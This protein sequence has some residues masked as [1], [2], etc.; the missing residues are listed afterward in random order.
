[1]N[2]RIKARDARRAEEAAQI[3]RIRA[4]HAATQAVV[5]A[6]VCPLCAQRVRRNNALAG[7]WQCTQFGTTNFRARSDLPSCDWQGFTE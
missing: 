4:A 6:G 1:M 5:D 3:A 7:W 2:E